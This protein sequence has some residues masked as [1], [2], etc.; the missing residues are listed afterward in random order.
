MKI[1]GVKTFVVDGGYRPWTF[2]KVETSEPGLVGW[3]DCSDWFHTEP[4]VAFVKA[5]GER[6]IGRDPLDV[7][8]VWWFLDSFTRH[9]G[10][11]AFRAMAGID[12]A[13]WDIRGKA[14]NAP[15][16]QLLG[17]KIHGMAS[18]PRDQIRLYW[19]HCGTSRANRQR[20]ERLRKKPVRTTADLR[21]F[22]EEVAS[23]G[24]TA[25]KTNWT[26]KLEDAPDIARPADHEFNGS[27]PP[28]MRR[29]AETV[30][31][32]FREVLGPDVG[33][34]L[35]VGWALRLG[36]AIEL[37]R[38]L[39]PYR[40]MWLE[41]E[42]FDAEAL[43]LVRRSTSTPIC[44]GESLYGL[45]DFKPFLKLHAQDIIMPDLAFNGITMGKKIADLA[46]AHDT[47][48]APHNCGSPL[49]TLVAANVCATVPNFLVLEFDTDD[50]PWRDDLMTHPFT[51]ER[52]RLVLPDRP[53]L[54][55]DL[56]EE[57]LVKHAGTTSV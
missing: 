9:E 30:I 10:G 20:A 3:G 29:K 54:G 43:A 17:G 45:R 40:L 42:T 33:I 21:R 8:A 52:G 24:Y 27:L 4:V 32:I 14:Y 1:T 28:W 37:A 41:T 12:S 46:H 35:D 47:L 31:G 51:I 55:S 19:S 23:A 57:Q 15:V 16:W 39:E 48:F 34:A 7:E 50:V 11:T 56:V 18:E 36:G 25:I 44:H 26:L 38:A 13:L 49:G 22:A 53:G 6:V 5:F 2:V